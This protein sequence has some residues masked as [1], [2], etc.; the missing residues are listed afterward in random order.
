[1]KETFPAILPGGIMFYK[2]TIILLSLFLTFPSFGLTVDFMPLAAGNTWVF[3]D[4]GY[5]FPCCVENHMHT[6]TIAAIG[7]TNGD[8]T[9]FTASVHDS[10]MVMPFG[11]SSHLVDSNYSVSCIKTKDS[12]LVGGVFSSFFPY[13]K[14]DTASWDSGNCCKSSDS[15]SYE[16]FISI[17]SNIVMFHVRNLLGPFEYA[18]DS[19]TVLANVGLL[20]FVNHHGVNLGTEGTFLNSIIKLI[21]FNG[22]PVTVPAEGI[23]ETKANQYTYNKKVSMHKIISLQGTPATLPGNSNVLYDLHGRMVPRPDRLPANGVY[24]VVPKNKD[25][26]A[27]PH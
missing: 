15:Y 20:T 12:V 3:T 4:S 24:F 13:S 8:T 2:K 6:F 19:Q 7:K 11:A 14:R 1:M 5:G 10:G 27:L 22:E 9:L 16:H 26:A 25:N 17:M 18:S 23:I 21:S